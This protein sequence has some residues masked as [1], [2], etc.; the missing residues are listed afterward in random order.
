MDMA[1][2]AGM[3]RPAGKSAGREARAGGER[4]RRRPGKPRV[5]PGEKNP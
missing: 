1:S 3:R 5:S 2:S 4:G